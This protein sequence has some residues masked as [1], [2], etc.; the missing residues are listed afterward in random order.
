MSS[1]ILHSEKGTI[2]GMEI[3]SGVAQV[4]EEGWETFW[5]E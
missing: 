1:F 4:K 5:R 3:R 2:L